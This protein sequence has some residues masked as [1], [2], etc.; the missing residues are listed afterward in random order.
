ML[1]ADYFRLLEDSISA[2]PAIISREITFE[3]RTNHIGLIKGILTFRDGS[4]LHFKEFV[5]VGDETVKYKYAYHFQ[6]QGKLVFR[7]DNHPIPLKD[8]PPCHK[9]DAFEENIVPSPA[10]ALHDVLREI[11]LLLPS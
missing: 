4:Q 6:R 8:I 11:L 7:Y 3:Q 2:F 9:H 5:E 1:I 10:P